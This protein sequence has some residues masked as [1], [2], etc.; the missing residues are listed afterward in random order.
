MNITP[1]KAACV[2]ICA[3]L[4]ATL[5]AGC[6][7]LSSNQ[8]TQSGGITVTDDA[9]R[10]VTVAQTPHRIIS[11]APSITEDLFALG[12]GGKVVGDTTYDNYPPA[13]VNITKVGGFSSP[14]IEKI[15]SLNPDIVFASS[16]ENNTLLS[17][18]SGYGIPTVVLNPT[19]L[20]AILNDLSMIG[21]VTGSTGNSSALVANLTQKMTANSISVASHPR[22]LYLVWYDP[23]MSAGANT[24]EGD[25]IAHAGGI[26]VAQ[27]A[28]VSGYG[29]MSKESIVALNPSV[30]I[31]N[32]AMNS[33]AV[34]QVK[35]DPALVTVDAVKNG[36]IYILDSDIISRPGPR[37]FDALEQ[38]AGIIRQAS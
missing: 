1:K 34:Q 16:L 19:S 6:A 24:F 27:L 25:I 36:K 31:A 11:L 26:N 38:I 7:Q 5:G 29:T 10:T 22:V 13:A 35:S 21:K 9:G 17:T 14:S 23:I 20:T 12:L 28:N 37:A 18:L 8:T 3:I 33:T 2:V 32:S 4:L 15:V 30:I